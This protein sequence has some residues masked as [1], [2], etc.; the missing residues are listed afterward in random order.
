MFQRWAGFPA[1]FFEF[2]A[3]VGD[4]WDKVW[5]YQRTGFQTTDGWQGHQDS[6][7]RRGTRTPEYAGAP[8]AE[9]LKGIDTL[10]LW[11]KS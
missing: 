10:G 1:I 4:A 2:G 6:R 9:F 5:S 3:A 11:G 8:E 7:V